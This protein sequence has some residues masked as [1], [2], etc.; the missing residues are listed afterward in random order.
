MFTLIK[1][2]GIQWSTSDSRWFVPS[3]LLIAQ[4]FPIRAG[5]VNPEQPTLNVAVSSFDVALPQGRSRTAVAGQAGNTMHINVA[6]AVLLFCLCFVSLKHHITLDKL[7]RL[8]D[9]PLLPPTHTLA[10]GI[11]EM[12]ADLPPAPAASAP[13]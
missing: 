13:L 2:A 5:L 7:A 8:H 6:G 11:I 12:A 9:G 1:N 10:A 3:E 4:G